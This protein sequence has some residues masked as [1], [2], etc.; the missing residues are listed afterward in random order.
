MKLKTRYIIFF[1]FFV[2]FLISAIFIL[3]Y[4]LGYR[5]DFKKNIWQKTGILIL[6]TD[7]KDAVIFLNG[8]LQKKK[9]PTKIINLFPRDYSIKLQ[10]SGFFDWQKKIT[11]NPNL[12]TFVENITLFKKDQTFTLLL[13]KN[14][15]NFK[16][17]SNGKKIIF[18][19]KNLKGFDL[20]SFNFETKEEKFIKYFPFAQ[21]IKINNFSFNSSEKNIL[22]EGN[23]KLGVTNNLILDL[24]KPENI[25]SLNEFEP[26]LQNIKWHQ[27]NDKILYGVVKTKDHFFLIE[28][29]LK[30]QK[31]ISIISEAT[32]ILDYFFDKASLYYLV[33]DLKNKNISL[34]KI[35]ENNSSVKIGKKITQLPFSSYFFIFSPTNILSILDKENQLLYLISPQ[36][37]IQKIILQAKNISWSKDGKKILYYNDF[38]L[39]ICYLNLEKLKESSYELLG[40]WTQEILKAIWYPQENYFIFNSDNLINAVEIDGLDQR[41]I[42]QLLKS[43][44]IKDLFFS[45]EDKI[46]YFIKE[47]KGENKLYKME[48]K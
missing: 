29:N 42:A 14:I 37:K 35:E 23:T 19:T 6:K 40:R 24:E 45:F 4:S 22:I 38:E 43:E 16:L 41:N 11:I 15:E 17:F 26:N 27:K 47:E 1:V 33:S 48:I 39:W 44:K 34:K 20:W 18:F 21:F 36:S 3:K 30:D 2:V 13:D 32:N 5:Y 9:T 10:N 31:I 46:L 25:I 8:K 28:I 7:P 12:T